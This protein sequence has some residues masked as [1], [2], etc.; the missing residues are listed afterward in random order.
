MLKLISIGRTPDPESGVAEIPSSDHTGKPQNGLDSL[1]ILVQAISF[2][3]G[4]PPGLS[5][6]KASPGSSIPGSKMVSKQ[7]SQRGSVDL[8]APPQSASQSRAHS[9]TPSEKADA[10]DEAFFN[11]NRRYNPTGFDSVFY[12][13]EIDQRLTE[14]SQIRTMGRFR[15]ETVS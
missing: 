5:S 6:K 14:R 8:P 11:Q 2:I 10:E 12:V 15:R 4:M 13:N 3:L 1:F 9:P 7:P